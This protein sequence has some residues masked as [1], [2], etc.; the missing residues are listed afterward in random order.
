MSVELG[1]VIG[2]V[3]AVAAV[4]LVALPFRAAEDDDA[5]EVPL[6]DLLARREMAYQLLRDLDLDFQSGKLAEDDYRPMHVQA[7][8]QAAEIVA[9][10]DAYEASVDDEAEPD[11]TDAD[12]KDIA[13]AAA[14]V[15][16]ASAGSPAA[17]CSYCGTER[18]DDD[19]FC[20]K[21]GRNLKPA[22][23]KHVVA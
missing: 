7:L 21:C 6:T 23:G 3:L 22:G 4:V 12:V 14:A 17:F 20:R 16:P 18:H 5:S 8:A 2:I 13:S 10:I 19:L 1:V 11:E 9:Q 15:A